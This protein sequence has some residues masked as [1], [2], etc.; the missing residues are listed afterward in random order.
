MIWAKLCCLFSAIAA[1]AACGA[2]M[3][4]EISM[5]IKFSKTSFYLGE[6]VPAEIHYKNNASKKVV[7]ENP[8]QSFEIIMHVFDS[9]RNEE[10]N[11]TM[12]KI[13]ITVMN[14][15]ADQYSKSIPPKEM[16]TIEANSYLNFIS[17]LNDRLYFH[18]GSFTCW[19]SEG[20]SVTNKVTIAIRFARESVL[21]MIQ[22]A[23]DTDTSYGRREWAMNWLQKI[24]PKLKLD[25]P[26]DEDAP[27]IKKEKESYN[28]A[29]IA[30]FINWWHDNQ[31]SDKVEVLIQNANSGK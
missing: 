13:Q 23:R 7:I 8:A 20:D 4:G 3:E 16:V 14:K 19:L 31:N 29:T 1:F 17:D 22:L 21:P 2:K 27:E 30:E 6:S 12:G 5:V 24:Y 15:S 26:Y 9:T 10:L 11:Y 28:G 25:L 18:P